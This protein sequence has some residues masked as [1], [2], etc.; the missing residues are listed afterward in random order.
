MVMPLAAPATCSLQMVDD[1]VIERQGGRNAGFFTGIAQDWRD[2]VQTYIDAAGSPVLIPTWPDI[3]DKKNSFLNLYLSP[4]DGSVQGDMLRAMREHELSLCPACGEAGAPNTL[5][6]YLPKGKYPHFCVTP[7][8]LFPMCDACQKNKEEKTGDAT[9]PRFFLHPYFDVFIANQVVELLIEPP[10]DAPTFQLGAVAGLTTSQST[11]V[12]R[13]LKELG[14][15]PRYARFFRNQHQRLLR[16]V[17]CLREAGLEV[18]EN[19][20]IF[21][22]NSAQPTRN[23]WEH[24]F[25]SAVL[26]NA[27]MRSYLTEEDLPAYR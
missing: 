5:D 8:N 20:I 21:R 11:L 13:H 7:H 25:Y 16:L 9:D 1:V 15:V 24:V 17:Q 22:D 18:E 12:T 3:D 4:R 23:A 14:I 2:R 6:H 10:F 27:D 26:S 19:L